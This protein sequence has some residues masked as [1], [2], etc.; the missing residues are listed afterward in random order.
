MLTYIFPEI[1][2]RPVLLPES[3]RV[4]LY[5]LHLRRFSGPIAATGFSPERPFLYAVVNYLER[6]FIVRVV[7]LCD[8]RRLQPP[9]S[10]Q[11]RPGGKTGAEH[12][13]YW[14]LRE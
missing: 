11:P 7:R 2:V 6:A 3:F 4:L 13:F 9:D 14:R 8:K 10:I 5:P 12:F 1:P